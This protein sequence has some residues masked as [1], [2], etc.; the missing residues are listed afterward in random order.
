MFWLGIQTQQENHPKKRQMNKKHCLVKRLK[1]ETIDEIVKDNIQEEY[2]V[3]KRE[4]FVD[5]QIRGPH[6]ENQVHISKNIA[7]TLEEDIK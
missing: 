3:A 6:N 7:E 2:P 4:E 5:E 1:R